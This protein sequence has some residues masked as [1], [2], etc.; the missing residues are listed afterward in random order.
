MLKKIASYDINIYRNYIEK[1]SQKMEDKNV[2]KYND[3][4]SK[5]C[6]VSDSLKV[7]EWSGTVR[8]NQR[9]NRKYVH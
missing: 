6:N 2:K 7:F 5:D 9:K 4:N 1:M 3:W 8:F